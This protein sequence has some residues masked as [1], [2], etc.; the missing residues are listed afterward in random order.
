MPL[1]P[2]FI[3]ELLPYWLRSDSVP[4]FEPGGRKTFVEMAL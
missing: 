2:L 3:A 4:G 1:Y